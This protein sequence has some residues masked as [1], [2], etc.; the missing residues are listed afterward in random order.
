MFVR[1]CVCVCVCVRRSATTKVTEI[2]QEVGEQT[3][4][5]VESRRYIALRRSDGEPVSSDEG[6][7][8]AG[9]GLKNDE[10]LTAVCGGCRKDRKQA[11][12]RG[13]RKE[14]EGLW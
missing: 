6:Q 1:A 4:L 11:R 9:V 5:P 2:V 10:Q 7:H 8:V 12:K 14:K 13:R 3:G